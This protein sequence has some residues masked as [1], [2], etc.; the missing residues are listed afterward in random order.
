MNMF[1]HGLFPIVLLLILN[2]K[3][4]WRCI[5]QLHISLSLNYI[6]HSSIK[7]LVPTEST[8]LCSQPREVRHTQVSL[9]IVAVFIMCHSVRWIPN[10]WEMKQAGTDMVGDK[11]CNENSLFF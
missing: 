7:N 1:F 9:V 6:K 8:L 11:T 2:I 5:I 4:Y 10:V 3:I